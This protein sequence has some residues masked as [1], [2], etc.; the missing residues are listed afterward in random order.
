MA[1]DKHGIASDAAAVTP[2]DTTA[3]KFESIYT[4]SGGAIAV[5]TQD[6][7]TLTFASTAAGTV[8]PIKTTLVLSTNTTATGIVGFR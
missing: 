6:G 1:I 2:H 3:N 8:L 4:G 5:K 7:T